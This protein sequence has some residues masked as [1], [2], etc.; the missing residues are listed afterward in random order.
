MN[1]YIQLMSEAAEAR[2]RKQASLVLKELKR[3]NKKRKKREKKAR[4]AAKHP[5]VNTGS[6]ESCST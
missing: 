6:V 5:P 1:D 4:K 2:T 3:L